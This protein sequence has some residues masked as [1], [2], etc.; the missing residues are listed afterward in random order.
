MRKSVSSIALSSILIVF[1]MYCAMTQRSTI[2]A[3]GRPDD[4]AGA[5]IAAEA[6][7]LKGLLAPL[8]LP[9]AENDPY[10]EQLNRIERAAQ[11]GNIFLSLFLLQQSATALPA[12]EY[13]N[14]KVDV[15]KGG[16]DALDREW[17]QLGGVLEE[18]E[19][20]LSAASTRRSPLVVDAIIER[21]LT[22][23]QPNYQSGRLYAQQTKVEYGL[24]YLGRAKA[25]LD[26]ALFCRGLELPTSGAPT[27]MRS[28]AP[29]LAELE[30]EVLQAYRQVGATDQQNGFIRINAS[31]KVAQDLEKEKRYS[32]ALLQYLEVSRALDAVTSP[33]IANPPSDT[34][35]SQLESFRARLSK[36]GADHSI[37]WLYWQMAQTAMS[38]GEGGKGDPNQAAVILRQVV[39]RYFKYMARIKS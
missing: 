36:G 26:F 13:Q 27:S 3:G 32:G 6:G 8:K 16:L 14:A 20:R 7:R 39:P 37:G 24:F 33:S 35:K 30:R 38:P 15:E 25:L 22:Q 21:S 2:A 29:E 23:V 31:L 10:L 19:R 34:L 17:R 4:Q 1:G 12:Y 5:A 11:A 18:K 9:A 28:L